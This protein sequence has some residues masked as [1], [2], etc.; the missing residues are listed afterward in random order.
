MKFEDFYTRYIGEILPEKPSYIRN[1]QALMNFLHEIWPEESKRIVEGV[2]PEQNL[3]CFHNDS[4]VSITINHLE[5][6]WHKK[7]E[8][9][10]NILD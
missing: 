5:K 6:V 9:R 7:D 1:G 4:Y 10:T 3:D 2:Y 8:E